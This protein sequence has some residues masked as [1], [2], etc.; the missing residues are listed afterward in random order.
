MIEYSKLIKN[1]KFKEFA[2]AAESTMDE[3]VKVAILK[4]I[5]Q[6]KKEL[7]A[8]LASKLV[9]SKYVST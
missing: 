6:K 2:A 3:I 4:K 7:G 1:G 8:K 5:Q 9:G